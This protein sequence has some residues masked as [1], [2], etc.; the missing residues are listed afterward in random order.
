LRARSATVA[1]GGSARGGR[2]WARGVDG[3]GESADELAAVLDEQPGQ[4]EG[5]GLERARGGGLMGRRAG[6]G[7]GVT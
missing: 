3:A 6:C 4:V 7:V 5:E 2:H 1:S